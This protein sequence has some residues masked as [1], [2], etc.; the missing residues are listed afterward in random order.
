ME[1]SVPKSALAL[2]SRLWDAGY[3][4]YLV[5]GCVRDLLRGEAPSDYDMTTSA[6]PHEMKAVFADYR[7]VESGMRHGTLTVLSDGIPYEITAYRIDGTYSDSRHPDAV[8]F[9]RSLTEDLARRDFTVNAM[10]YAPGKGL[11]DP[12]GGRADL[13]AGVLRA[14]G[15]PSRRFTE[16]ALRIL[17]ALR[18]SS[19]LGYEIESGTALA[20]RALAERISRVSAERIR[21]EISKLLCGGF[22]ETVLLSYRDVLAAAFP[23]LAELGSVYGEAVGL[24]CSLPQAALTL[25][26]AAL[27]SPLSSER[28]G[29]ALCALRFDRKTTDRVTAALRYFAKPLPRNDVELLRLLSDVGEEGARDRLVLAELS[30]PEEAGGLLSRLDALLAEGRC[31]RICDLAING[32]QLLQN[33][34]RTG[35]EIGEVL[36]SLLDAVISGELPNNAEQLLER[37][38]EGRRE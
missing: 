36:S 1:F 37:A 30:A 25:R 15:D 38:L 17:R 2:L 26:L 4:A 5:G 27:L 18:F 28:A 10:A 13:Q 32:K 31:Y 33:G 22:A 8:R 35:R 9:T 14:V 29:Q 3:E 24:A 16:D 34:F 21:T 12:F 20:A 19:V 11:V 7:T 6:E 23:M